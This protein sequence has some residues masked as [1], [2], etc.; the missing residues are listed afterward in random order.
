MSPIPIS[1]QNG[2]M[3][4]GLITLPKAETK[5]YLGCV[6]FSF[7][8]LSYSFLLHCSEDRLIFS[9]PNVLSLLKQTQKLLIFSL[10]L[11]R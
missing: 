11:S 3:Q 2:V 6:S 8:S 4:I 9:H 1:M 7:L 5:S 10:F